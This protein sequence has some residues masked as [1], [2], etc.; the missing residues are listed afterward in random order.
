MSKKIKELRDLSIEELGLQHQ[1]LRKE[2]F[3]RLNAKRMSGKSEE[4]HRIRQAR[5]EIA[6]V[7]T[8]LK[9][10]QSGSPQPSAV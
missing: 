9:E 6:R 4:P 5:R 3:E 7:L 10:K 1:E 8:V 2:I